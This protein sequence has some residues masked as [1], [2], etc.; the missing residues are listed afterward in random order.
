MTHTYRAA[1]CQRVV[2]ALTNPVDVASSSMSRLSGTSGFRVT[3]TPTVGTHRGH[4]DAAWVFSRHRFG[5]D[6]AAVLVRVSDP[7]KEADPLQYELI[8]HAALTRFD[9]LGLENGRG[10]GSREKGDQCLGGLGIL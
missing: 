4:Y 9:P 7:L 8:A 10:L 2:E 1:C 5:P 6:V 3:A